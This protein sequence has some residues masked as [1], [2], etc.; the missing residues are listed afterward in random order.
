MSK[1]YRKLSTMQRLLSYRVNLEAR[2]VSRA[3]FTV[4]PIALAL[5][6]VSGCGPGGR[7]RLVGKWE[8]DLS[9]A[10]PPKS[11]PAEKAAEIMAS[12][13]LSVQYNDDGTMAMTVVMADV[14]LTKHYRWSV[15]SDQGDDLM[16]RL[17]PDDGSAAKHA[18]IHFVNDDRIET[19]SQHPML[20][21][22]TM[23]LRRVAP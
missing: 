18:A 1:G 9:N 16:L 7:E 2:I 12:T 8:A 14:E 13:K 17:Q 15:E 23:A 3:A 20:G 21:S 4:L 11:L 10:T 22:D 5:I 6:V 19:P